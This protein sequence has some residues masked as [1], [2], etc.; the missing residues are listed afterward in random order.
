MFGLIYQGSL[1]WEMLSGTRVGGK[2]LPCHDHDI[3]GNV[4]FVLSGANGNG[5]TK[6]R[7]LLCSINAQLG[8]IFVC[9]E[10]TWDHSISTA[11]YRGFGMRFFIWSDSSDG[12]DS[13]IPSACNTWPRGKRGGVRWIPCHRSSGSMWVHRHTL[14][15]SS[16]L[17]PSV[18]LGRSVWNVFL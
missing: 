4:V 13:H 16:S 9:I 2:Q 18:G 17:G 8:E 12:V 11:E 15:M 6:H 5:S 7:W 3:A 10:I 1:N 14:A